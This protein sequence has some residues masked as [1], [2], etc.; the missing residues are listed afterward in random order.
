MIVAL[1]IFLLIFSFLIISHEFGHFIVAKK[2][3]V[4]VEEFGLGYPPR[5]FG[6][7]VGETTY[8]INWIPFGGFVSLYGENPEERDEEDETNFAAKSPLTKAGILSAG[9]I[10]NFLTAVVIF[11][12]LLAFSG[13]QTSQTQLFDYQFP[14]GQQTNH[15][16]VSQVAT[17]SP[18]AFSDIESYDLILSA[19]GEEMNEVSPIYFFC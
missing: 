13:F 16:V 2:S 6:K 15:P 7:K 17:G 1:I 5:I 19:D 11:Y 14:F 10:I 3:G 12:F 8:S 9:V 4:R 18:A